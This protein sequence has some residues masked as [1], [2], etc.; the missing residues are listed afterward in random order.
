MIAIKDGTI[1]TVKNGTIRDGVILVE[2]STIQEVGQGIAIPP[3]STVIDA[4]GCYVVPGFIDAHCHVGISEEVFRI[5]GNDINETTDPITPYL[6][7]LDGVNL[8]DL[9]FDDA[10]RSGG[11]PPDGTPGK[12][13]C[14][15]GSIG[16]A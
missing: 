3:S 15:R 6:Q 7:A 14:A 13:Q 10:V 12:R 2:G 5:E 16:T 9:A 1:V 8:N 11:N 4:A